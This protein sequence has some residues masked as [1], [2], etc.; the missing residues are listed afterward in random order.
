[1]CGFSECRGTL[2]MILESQN[3]WFDSQIASCISLLKAHEIFIQ[4][5]MRITGV[6]E[7][8]AEASCQA[9]KTDKLQPFQLV[10][11]GGSVPECIHLCHRPVKKDR[12][13]QLLA[14]LYPIRY[15]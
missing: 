5:T 11:I 6:Q 1:M 10:E 4:C 8:R 9:K 12:I 14:F 2:E 7:E 15:F 3:L 13:M